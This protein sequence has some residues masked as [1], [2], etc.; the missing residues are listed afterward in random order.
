MIKVQPE[1]FQMI[2]EVPRWITANRVD[3]FARFVREG[4][5]SEVVR[6]ITDA[7]VV[8]TVDF[9]PYFAQP[10]L[11]RRE[12][13]EIWKMD[14]ISVRVAFFWPIRIPSPSTRQNAKIY[15]SDDRSTYYLLTGYHS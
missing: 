15:R 5:R 10:V 14:E 9:F 11:S 13:K 7:G 12:R 6:R 3:V 2:V 4:V 1:S 8:G